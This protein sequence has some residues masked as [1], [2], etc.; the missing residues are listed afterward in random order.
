MPDTRQNAFAMTLPVTTM[1][2]VG[3]MIAIP[4]NLRDGTT[5][6]MFCCLSHQPMP[7]LNERDHAV[8][9]T[10]ANLV[11]EV[12]GAD[13]AADRTDQTLRQQIEDV[14]ADHDF[15]LL[16]QPIVSLD[17]NTVM[18]AE[19]LCRFRATPYRSPDKWFADARRV[20]LER[21]LER[22]VIEKTLALLPDLPRALKL[23]INVSPDMVIA[24]D[25]VSLID[26]PFSDRII[27]ELTEHEDFGSLT[28]LQQQMK[29]LRR[30]G[31]QIA[32]DDLG[33]TYLSLNTVLQIK[34]DIV[35]LDREMVRGINLDPASR[36]LAAGIKHFADAIG[37]QVVAE[38]IERQEEADTLRSLGIQ[39]GQGFLLG[40]PGGVNALQARTFSY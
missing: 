25:L 36:A 39:F 35:K 7:A 6:G 18:G 15:Q 5:Y 2:P 19:A 34:P 37:A 20:G 28:E 16:L 32:V 17:D 12:I 26:G 8:M 22:A 23:S 29:Q 40:R 13:I 38:G 30:L 27:F 10:F 21:H 31:A 24:G 1:A 4:L 14:M 9:V 3:A 11:A 33:A